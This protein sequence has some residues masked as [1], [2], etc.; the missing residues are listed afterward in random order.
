MLCTRQSNEDEIM[1]QIDC[2]P[3]SCGTKNNNKLN[4]LCGRLS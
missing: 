2:L 1:N 4:L 3:V